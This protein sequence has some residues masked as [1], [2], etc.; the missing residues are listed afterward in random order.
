MLADATQIDPN[1]KQKDGL[2]SYFLSSLFRRK[3]YV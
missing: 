1:T 2:Q 3:N